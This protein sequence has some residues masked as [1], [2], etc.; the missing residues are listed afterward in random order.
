M[1]RSSFPTEVSLWVKSSASLLHGTHAWRLAPLLWGMLFARGRRTVT[2]WLR[3]GELSDDPS[4]AR[5]T[6]P[7]RCWQGWRRCHGH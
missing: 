7:V 3:A 1:A 2:S 4:K 5:T 6:R